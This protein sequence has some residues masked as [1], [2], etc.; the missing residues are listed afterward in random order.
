MAAGGTS[1]R[2]K[3]VLVVEDDLLLM[4]NLQDMLADFGC[5]VVGSAMVVD[6]AL[7][8]ARDLPIDLAVLDVN[9]RGE[10]VTPVAEALVARGVPF[11][12]ATGYDSQILASLAD[13]PRLAKPYS[14][15][16][17]LGALLKIVAATQTP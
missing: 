10:L 12:F 3:R 9:L 11:L 8:L 13:R 1:L 5:R 16:Q 6:N 2:D 7:A 15:D 17:L 4:M 14:A